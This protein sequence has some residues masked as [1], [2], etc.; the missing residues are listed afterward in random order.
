MGKYDKDR[1]LKELAVRYCLARGMLPYLEVVVSNV[2]E[3]SD[4]I[5]VLTDIDVLG[6]QANQSG[7]LRKTIFD[8]KTMNKM[9]PINRAFWAA[10]ILRYA[11]CQEALVILKSMAVHN[12][13]ISALSID[14]DLHDES[15]FKDLGSSFNI[16][17][18]RDAKY[19][20]SLERWA[21]VHKCYTSN[22][23]SEPLFSLV[24]NVAPLTKSP[25]SVFRHIVAELR[26]TRGYFD[27]DKDA[28]IAIFLD[29]L[30]SMFLLWTTLGRD[31]RR[32]YDP[33]MKKEDFERILR[34]YIWG[35]KESYLIRKQLRE[36][37]G[38]ENGPASS[39]DLPE[40]QRLVSFVGIIMSAPQEIFRCAD[41]CREL[42]IR[43][44]SGVS[45][46]F[47]L[48]LAKS[49]RTNKRVRQ[50]MLALS[51]Y[52]IAASGIPKDLNSRIEKVLLS[53]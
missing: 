47:D 4:S 29:T 22:A 35:G 34:Y 2:T 45:E 10:G 33:A 30:S 42:S 3:L 5:E 36:K 43:F 39:F 24:R 1:F 49:I 38:T 25:W 11:R 18:A 13:R 41:V 46:E 21:D 12:H 19:Q 40:W 52:L 9:S 16:D 32:L 50:F 14:V 26:S 28:H 23:W 51:E 6:I 31:I 8:C 48:L 37:I 27:P 53:W 44:G 17:F 7:G 15:S 20:S